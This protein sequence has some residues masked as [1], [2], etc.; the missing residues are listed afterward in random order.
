MLKVITSGLVAGSRLLLR[1]PKLV[2][3]GAVAAV[4]FW[5]E[6]FGDASVIAAVAMHREDTGQ[7]L[8]P[9]VV[10]GDVALLQV[11]QQEEIGLHLVVTC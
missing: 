11:L 3:A 9:C 8:A 7:S 4:A 2:D 5:S 6:G 1:G 10:G